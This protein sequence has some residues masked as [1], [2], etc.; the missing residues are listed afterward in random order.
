MRSRSTRRAVLG[1]ALGVMLFSASDTRAIVIVGGL[2]GAHFAGIF[3]SSIDRSDTGFFD[4]FIDSVKN[5]RFMCRLKV[6]PDGPDIPC[7][8]T[9]SAAGVFEVI[10]RRGV[11]QVHGMLDAFGIAQARYRFGDDEG[12]L[13]MVQQTSGQPPDPAVF[14]S[15]SGDFMSMTT[16]MDGMLML[17]VSRE[18][19]MADA[20]MMVTEE[21]MDERTGETMISMFSFDVFVS[22][23]PPGPCKEGEACMHPFSLI[24]LS[25]M[26]DRGEFVVRGTIGDGGAMGEYM[27]YPMGIDNPDLMDGGTFDV[28]RNISPR[29]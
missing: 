27:Y 28:A 19:N 12:T 29:E 23:L 9:L 13:L 14:G 4:V 20:L 21:T 22:G 18:S 2:E 24:G 25:S 15:F 1:I 6:A 8:G 7:Q 5:R 11:F 26:G 16:M 3:Q 17:D 10:A